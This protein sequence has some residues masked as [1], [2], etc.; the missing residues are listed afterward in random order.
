[1]AT[2]PCRCRGRF[3]Q[4][5]SLQFCCSAHLSLSSLLVHSVLYS[6]CDYYY[7]VCVDRAIGGNNS[8]NSGSKQRWKKASKSGGRS[9]QTTPGRH[10]SWFQ[11]PSGNIILL[12]HLSTLISISLVH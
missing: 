4:L 11:P 7:L 10:Y 6:N 2:R 3:I 8:A 9:S 5:F 1:M 12:R